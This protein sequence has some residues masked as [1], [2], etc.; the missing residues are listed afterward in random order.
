MYP[1]PA[2]PVALLLLTLLRAPSAQDA[3]RPVNVC[4]SPDFSS[5]HSVSV[6]ACLFCVVAY[7][8]RFSILGGGLSSVFSKLSVYS[9]EETCVFWLELFFF[10]LNWSVLYNG[11]YGRSR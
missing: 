2:G 6:S 7:V 11:T 5:I 8:S 9:F 4:T 1:G 10:C 3:G